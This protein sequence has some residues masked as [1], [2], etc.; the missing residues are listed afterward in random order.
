MSPNAFAGAQLTIDL[1]AISANWRALGA[2][3]KNGA[4]AAAVVKANAYG[5]GISAVAPALYDAGCRDF[6]TPRPT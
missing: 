5:L 3:L 2:R 6:G 1:D 4:Q